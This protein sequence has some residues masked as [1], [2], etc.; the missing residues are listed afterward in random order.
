LFWEAGVHDWICVVHIREDQ[1][2][3]GFGK[4]DRFLLKISK[5]H[6]LAEKGMSIVND[7]PGDYVLDVGGVRLPKIEHTGIFQTVANAKEGN[8]IAAFLAK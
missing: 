2:E 5:Y 7:C 1:V 8:I 4:K 3:Q 6:D